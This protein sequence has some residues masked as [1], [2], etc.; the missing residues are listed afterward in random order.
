MTE[1]DQ[2]PGH[3]IRRMQQIAVAIFLQET[4]PYGITPVQCAAMMTVRN[5]PGMDQRTLA[6][7]IG[8]DTSTIATVIDRLEARDLLRRNMSSTD[9]R[10]RLI[11]LTDK[12]R[13]LLQALMPS[14]VGAQDLMLAPLSKFERAE[15]L[16]MLRKLVDSNNELSRAP[17]EK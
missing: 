4:E 12:G 13:T 5:G 7:S 17:S 16:R 9:A 2:F 14:V 6:R 11:T 15:F 1:I 3:L 10:V 8:F